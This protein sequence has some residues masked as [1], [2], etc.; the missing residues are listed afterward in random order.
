MQTLVE[1]AGGRGVLRPEQMQSNSRDDN[2]GHHPCLAMLCPHLTCYEVVDD[3]IGA[4][5]CIHCTSDIAHH[6]ARLRV[7]RNGECLVLGTVSLPKPRR[8]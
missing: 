4:L 8:R 3:G 7:L 5:I 6:G 1:H 2:L